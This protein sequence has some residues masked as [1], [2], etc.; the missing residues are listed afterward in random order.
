M[1]YK[2][3]YIY[4][5]FY[6]CIYGNSEAITTRDPF[7]SEPKKIPSSIILASCGGSGD[8][9]SDPPK[10]RKRPWCAAVGF[11]TPLENTAH[12]P[13]ALRS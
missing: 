13:Y 3:I 2:Y 1:F 5:M 9:L 4:I 12:H 11:C 7:N 6:I 8:F 10:R